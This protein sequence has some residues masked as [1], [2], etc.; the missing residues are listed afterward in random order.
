ML[1]TFQEIEQLMIRAAGGFLSDETRDAFRNEATLFE[2]TAS[3]SNPIARLLRIAPSE[4]V[5]RLVLV[6]P[7]RR[8][9]P[10][11]DGSLAYN[12]SVRLPNFGPAFALCIGSDPCDPFW[13]GLKVAAEWSRHMRQD[14]VQEELAY[15]KLV[16]LAL[17]EELDRVLTRNSPRRFSKGRHD[18]LDTVFRLTDIVYGEVS[19]RYAH[20]S[21]LSEEVTRTHLIAVAV[22]AASRGALSIKVV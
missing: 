21:S 4:D 14:M 15:G 3:A 17:D 5:H 16:A 2:M 1:R 9:F 19:K 7:P 20:P 8:R 13:F 6:L 18:D 12:V 10:N 11:H 22:S